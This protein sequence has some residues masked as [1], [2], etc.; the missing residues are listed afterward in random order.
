MMW[1]VVEGFN[2]ALCSY[3]QRTLMSELTAKNIGN[4]ETMAA[5]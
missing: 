1:Q 2:E 4:E 5:L 3:E